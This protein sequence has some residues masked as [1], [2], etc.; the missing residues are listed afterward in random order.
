VDLS[1]ISTRKIGS[2]VRVRFDFKGGKRVEH[3]LP[4]FSA[5][6]ATFKA[7]IAAKLL[8]A[9]VSLGAFWV[10]MNRDKSVAVATGVQPKVWPEDE[11]KAVKVTP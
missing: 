8:M 1:G 6:D 9:K 4:S 7:D 11:G 5:T 10:H 2:D 3:K